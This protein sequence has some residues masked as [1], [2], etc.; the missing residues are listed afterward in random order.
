MLRCR[1]RARSCKDA[2]GRKRARAARSNGASVTCSRASIARRSASCGARS[3]RSSR[4]TSRASCSSGSTSARRAASAGRR[5]SPACWP[6]SKATRRRLRRGKA[7]CCRRGSTTTRRPG[8]TSCAP[9]AARCGRGCVRRAGDSRRGGATSLRATP[10]LLL[11]RRTAPLWTPLAPAPAADDRLGSRARRV[12]EFLSAMAHRSS[13]TSSPAPTAARRARG[14]ALR[15][16]RARARPLRQLRR[17]ACAARAAVEAE[18]SGPARP[19][20]L[21]RHPGRRPLVARACAD[22]RAGGAVCAGGSRAWLG[23]ESVEHV[24]RI[25]LRRYGVVCWR[26]MEREPAWL[27]PWR[28][29]VRVYRRLEARGEI[30][31]GR[32]VAGLSGE[33]Y[34]LPDAVALMREVRRRPRDGSLVC[35]AA[36]DPAN[37]L[38]TP[39]P[40]RDC[41]C[42]RRARPLSRRRA[43]GDGSAARSHGSTGRASRSDL[44]CGACSTAERSR[45]RHEHA[46]G[47]IAGR[48]AAP[49]SH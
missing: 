7:S 8:S 29:L 28:D 18:K 2:S 37:L 19:G 25:L 48:A 4:A 5:R 24:A 23:G 6:S 10:V 47:A 20:R 3:S 40:A 16:G 36:A 45:A 32:F 46:S 22:R 26:L 43:A 31:G 42:R 13:T 17:P 1:A 11:P 15:A 44:D 21:V 41:P 35:L 34:A 39:C 12:A 30:R 38:G 49:R 9:P 33:Q 14:R 27:P